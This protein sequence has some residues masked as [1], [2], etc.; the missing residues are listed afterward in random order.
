MTLSRRILTIAVLVV[1]ALMTVSEV[2]EIL[3]LTDDISNDYELAVIGRQ[4]WRRCMVEDSTRRVTSAHVLFPASDE[5]HD[6]F[7][8][9]F[10]LP[11]SST[12]PRNQLLTL[13]SQRK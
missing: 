6:A 9:K 8:H 13:M 2:P 12:F 3:A 10:L 1:G 11:P 7:A 5:D 4:S